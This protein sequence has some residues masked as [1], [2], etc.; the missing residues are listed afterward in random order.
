MGWLPLRQIHRFVEQKIPFSVQPSKATFS[1]LPFLHLLYIGLELF[2]AYFLMHV[3]HQWLA[4]D[5]DL[6][7]G[8][9]LFLAGIGYPIFVSTAFR[10][11]LLLSILGIYGFL[12]PMLFWVIPCVVLGLFFLQVPQRIAYALVGVFF[13]ALGWLQ[14]SNSL[15]LSVYVGLAIYLT[16][17][18]TPVISSIKTQ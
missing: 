3:V 2:R 13:I 15:Y 7:I 5:I 1:I 4:F 10:T 6:V 11:P 14:G 8:L 12:F 18:T 9:A 17:K 16:I